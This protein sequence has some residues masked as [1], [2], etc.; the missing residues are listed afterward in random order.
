ML[1]LLFLLAQASVSSATTSALFEAIHQR[2]SSAAVALINAG[3]DPNSRD[4]HARTPLHATV[5]GEGWSKKELTELL[6]LLLAKGADPNA[7]DD[8]GASPLDEAIWEGSFDR[9]VLL[10]DAGAQINAPETKTG[11]TPVNEAAFKGHLDLVKLLLARGA[12][13][14]LK[15][16]AGFS[17]IENAIRRHHTEL[18]SFLLSV[19]TNRESPSSLLEEAVRLGQADTLQVLLD[20]G[21]KLDAR[22]AA[23]STILYEAA[24]KGDDNIVSLLVDRGANV[25]LRETASGT[26]PLYAAAAFGREQVV[27]TLLLWGADPNLVSNE[28]MS[29][30]H[31][32]ESNKFMAIAKRIRAA[33]GR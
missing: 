6:Q 7:R 26:T 30:L 29:P 24:L 4:I 23:G 12:D 25:N 11:A 2:T 5:V 31:A 1:P 28:G 3:A 18:V 13:V 14:N 17:P 20:A 16:H 19:D 10:I 27:S 33:G 8:S 9:S 21:A 32:A 15:D 22:S